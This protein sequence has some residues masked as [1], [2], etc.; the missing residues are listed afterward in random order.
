M[1]LLGITNVEFLNALYKHSFDM[2]LSSH[3]L[4]SFIG[5]LNLTDKLVDE[6]ISGWVEA[7]N[8]LCTIAYLIL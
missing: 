1:K 2:H 7:M 4:G 6:K 8:N 5:T 3:F